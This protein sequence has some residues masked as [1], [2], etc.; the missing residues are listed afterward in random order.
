M[1][2][3][4]FGFFNPVSAPE[5]GRVLFLRDKSAVLEEKA[6]HYKTYPR[7]EQIV[8]PFVKRD[9]DSNQMAHFRFF[10]SQLSLRDISLLLRYSCGVIAKKDDV[11]VRAYASYADTYPVET[12]L[13]FFEHSSEIASGLYHYRVNTH[14]LEK[15][16]RGFSPKDLAVYVR[17]SL[18]ADALFTMFFT[19]I[20][21][22]IQSLGEEEK[23]R[24]ID[25]DVGRISQNAE[26]LAPLIGLQF[27]SCP[28]LRRKPLENFLDI[29]GIS[30]Q[31]VFGITFF[32]RTGDK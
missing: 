7:F 12:Y 21:S 25:F 28:D 32:F 5:R 11:T 16:W 4:F 2:N 29:D 20:P 17:D 10:P 19:V 26:S 30:E 23:V 9:E 3:S 15:M 31:V 13:V 8:L 18:A 6:I 24:S 1:K 14:T 27:Q 22:R